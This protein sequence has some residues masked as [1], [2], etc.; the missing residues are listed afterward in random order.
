MIREGLRLTRSESVTVQHCPA[1]PCRSRFGKRIPGLN[2][3]FQ[4]DWIALTPPKFGSCKRG[5]PNFRSAVYLSHI[6]ITMPEGGEAAARQFYGGHLGLREITKPEWLR[7]R[8]G[9]WFDAGGIHLHVSV[10]KERSEP[11]R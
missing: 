10:E 1:D 9:L 11:D 6:D 8:G 3:S 7:G 4:S 2:K 5:T